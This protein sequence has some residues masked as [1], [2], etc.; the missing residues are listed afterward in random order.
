MGVDSIEK[1]FIDE[2]RDLYSA[3]TQIAKTLPKLAKAADSEELR[4]SF[5]SH[6]RETEGHVRR[7]EQ[8]FEMIGESP[9]GR[10]CDGIKG[11]LSEGAK[12][13]RGTKEGPV[14]DEALIS[15]AQ[16]VEHYEMA[17]Y[18]TVRS[19]ADRMGQKQMAEILDRTLDEEKRADK[20]L[21][22]V[23]NSVFRQIRRAA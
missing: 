10:T 15:S 6:L 23:S 14:R 4:S 18:G 13:L 17:A 7:L 21:T 12:M 9:K 5:E 19:H 11:V 3:E 1:L 20:K 16:R 2:L 8:I 22:D